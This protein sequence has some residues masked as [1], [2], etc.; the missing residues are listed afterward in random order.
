MSRRPLLA[1]S[2]LAS[3]CGWVPVAAVAQS[4]P[5]PAASPSS[6]ASAET[7]RLLALDAKLDALSRRVAPSVV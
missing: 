4:R 6:P 5:Q 7:S 1:L 2:M 3:V